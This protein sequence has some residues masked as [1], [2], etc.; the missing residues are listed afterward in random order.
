MGGSSFVK[1]SIATPVTVNNGGT[2][3]T[4]AS[5]ALT[6]LGAMPI[7]GGTLTGSI[8]VLDLLI[9][10]GY[11]LKYNNN[12]VFLGPITSGSGGLAGQLLVSAG[13]TSS[14]TWSNNVTLSQITVDNTLGSNST[15]SGLL[16]SGTVGESVVFGDILYLKFSDGKWWKAK[17]DSYT[18]TPGAR[19]ALATI[20]A[21]ATGLL[22]IEGN[23]RYDSWSLA[24]NK[25]YLSAATA[26]ALTTTQP[27]TTGNQ[28]QVLGIAKTSTTMYFRPSYDI[29]EK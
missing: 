28:I 22:L 21:N 12:N 6:N 20:L 19:M 5:Q 8:T 29:G 4:T 17:A 2:G 11:N 15:Y 10:N 23:V 1:G 16:E 18:T 26:G 14:P 24:A 9:T 7:S 3:A 25:V 13:S 27:S